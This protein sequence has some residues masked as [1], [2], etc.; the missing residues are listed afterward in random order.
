[1]ITPMKRFQP[2]LLS[3]VLLIGV[4]S[5]SACRLEETQS[6]SIPISCY[7]DY[8]EVE[9]QLTN[10]DN[11]EVRELEVR[12]GVVDF[13]ELVSGR[14]EV[15]LRAWQDGYESERVR[16]HNRFNVPNQIPSSIL[17]VPRPGIIN[18]T[19]YS[20]QNFRGWVNLDMTFDCE[21][22]PDVFQWY[23]ISID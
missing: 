16:F 17:S 13:G 14:Y 2:V 7:N 10:L 22:Q 3:T 1:M 21:Q 8:D 11:N 23:H 15:N 5:F 9:I 4:L 20:V 18:N 6:I 19:D 12:N